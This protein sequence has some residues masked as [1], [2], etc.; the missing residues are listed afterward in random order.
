MTVWAVFSL[1]LRDNEN[2]EALVYLFET[3]QSANQ[4]IE[5]SENDESTSHYDL[6][7]RELKVFK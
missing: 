6:Y 4:W 3:E 1:D 7:Y 2:T 5:D